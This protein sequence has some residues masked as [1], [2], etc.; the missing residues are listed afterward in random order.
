M[1]FDKECLTLNANEKYCNNKEKLLKFYVN[2]EK[3]NE[4]GDYVFRDKDKLLISYGSENND[5]IGL[6]IDSITDFSENH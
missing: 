6:Q 4:F 2:G 3:N 1:K 5:A